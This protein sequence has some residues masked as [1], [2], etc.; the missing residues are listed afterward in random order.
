M[1]TYGTAVCSDPAVHPNPTNLAGMGAS[2]IALLVTPRMG[3]IFERKR[4]TFVKHSFDFYRP[5][6]WHN[7][8]ALMDLNI[9]TG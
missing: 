2:S 5:I 4:T 7:N 1:G 3:L 6:G 9:A 8:D